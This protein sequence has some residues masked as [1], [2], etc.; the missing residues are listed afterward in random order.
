MIYYRDHKYSFEEL[1]NEN[2]GFLLRS[3][4][5]IDGTESDMR[6]TK[7]S[8]P[9]LID[10]GIMGHCLA[11]RDGLCQR[12]GVDCYQNA[13]KNSNSNMTLQEYI[14]LINQCK[15]KTFQVALGG[16]GD[17]NKHDEFEQILYATRD[18]GIIPNLTTS[19]YLL[20]DKEINVMKEYCGAVGVSFYSTL[21]E[22]MKE[23]NPQTISAIKSLVSA[24]CRVNIHYVLSTSSLKEAKKRLDNGLFPKGIN[25]IVFLLYKSVGA[26][27]REK[28]I[29]RHDDAYIEFIKSINRFKSTYK[30]GF[31][32]CQAPALVMHNKELCIDTID[33]CEAARFSMYIDSNLVAYPCSFGYTQSVYSVNLND[34]SIETAWDSPQFELFRTRQDHSNSVGHSGCALNCI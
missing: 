18:N 28:V 6:V 27:K 14:H 26:G 16:A 9:E 5:I 3:N 30:I 4:V 17:P 32:T 34:I 15:G 22:T 31:D 20:T 19:G 8:F 11:A 13:T 25:A 1:F 21:D 12:A 29:H 23:T 10:I 33:F 7:R 2:T 24:G